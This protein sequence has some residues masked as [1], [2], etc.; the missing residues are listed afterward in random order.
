MSLSIT[1]LGHS[2]FLLRLPSGQRLLLDPWLGNPRCPPAFANPESLAPIDLVLV[3]HGHSD[4][5]TDLEAVVRATGAPVVC[6]FELG[7]YMTERGMQ[8]I[9]DMG[10]GGTRT[11]ANVTI[12][13]TMATHSA[14]IR[15]ASGT[16]YLGS[17]AGFI[18]RA[19][20]APVLY[21]AG[22][23]GL[24]GD[25]KIIAELYAPA[26]AFLP[27]GDVYTM[28]PDTAAIA[29]SWLGVRQ[30]VPMHWGTFPLLTGTPDALREHLAAIGRAD[31]E[32]LELQPGE[33]AD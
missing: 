10:I 30:V 11:V 4:H 8:G 13:M 22:D 21:F 29:A 7:E 27:I 24:F 6:G 32:V 2:V 33:T 12:T 3:S 17:P 14:S 5:M 20:G 31:I 19:P 18:I 23:T 28:G 1:W 16:V 26:I 25:M 9:H 15:D